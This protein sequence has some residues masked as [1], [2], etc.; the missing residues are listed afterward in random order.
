MQVRTLFQSRSDTIKW[1]CVKRERED[2]DIKT[3]GLAHPRARVHP[4]SFHRTNRETI[5]AGNFLLGKSRDKFEGL[6]RRSEMRKREKAER[7]GGL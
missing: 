7:E 4:N 5:A 6:E 3:S 1:G 2:A